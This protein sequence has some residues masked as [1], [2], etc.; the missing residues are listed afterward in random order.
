MKQILIIN[1]RSTQQSLKIDGAKINRIEG[2]NREYTLVG[3]F[4]KPLIIIMTFRDKINKE[5]EILNN[6]VN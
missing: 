2:R 3:D 6:T 5:I 1:I 4:N